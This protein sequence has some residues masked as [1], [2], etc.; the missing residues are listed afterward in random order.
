[1]TPRTLPLIATLWGFK[2]LAAFCPSYTPSSS[3]TSGDNCAIEAAVGTPPTLSEWTDIFAFVSRGPAAWGSDGPTAP[4]LTEGCNKP[5]AEHTVSARFPCELMKAI[6][7]QESLWQQFCVPTGPADQTGKPAQTIISF[8]CGYGVGQVTSGMR[9]NE[10]P[11]FDRSRVASQTVYNL[12]TGMRILAEKWQTTHCVGDALTPTIE[13]WYVATWAY[14]G[15]ASINNP[16]NPS[17]S[18]TRG[19]WNPNVG[20]SRPY[21]EKIWGWMEHPPTSNHWPSLT[22][23]YPDVSNLSAG[24]GA[25]AALGEPDCSTPTNCTTLRAQ[26]TTGCWSTDAGPIDAG[27]DAG[28]DAGPIDAGFDAGTLDAGFDAGF[29]AGTLTGTDGGDAGPVSDAGPYVQPPVSA[30]PIDPRIGLVPPGCGCHAA[31]LGALASLAV[32]LLGRRRKSP[33]R[34]VST[35]RVTDKR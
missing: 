11:S 2:A 6:A 16:A 35:S 15:L 12:A 33:A 23:A 28:F 20:G 25:P 34:D 3:S 18:S 17:Y 24:S 1:M 19:V 13:H 26:H 22:A 32:L 7:Y 30:S 4:N 10:S 27:F 9:L 8:D 5:T 31:P 14:N 21:Q 29:D